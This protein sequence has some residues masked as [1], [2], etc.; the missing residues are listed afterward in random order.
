MHLLPFPPNF[1]ELYNWLCII[2]MFKILIPFYRH[3][4]Y[5]SL[6][7]IHGL[8]SSVLTVSFTWPLHSLNLYLF[9]NGVDFFMIFLKD[10][11]MGTT[12][13]ELFYVWRCSFVDFES[14]L[15]V[16]WV[17]PF[18]NYTLF[19]INK[20][21]GSI[22]S[23][24][25]V[26]WDQLN[27]SLLDFI[28]APTYNTE[29]LL[30]KNLVRIYINANYFMFPVL[31]FIISILNF[32]PFSLQGNLKLYIFKYYGFYFYLLHFS[33][34]DSYSHVGISPAVFLI[35]YLPWKTLWLSGI[36]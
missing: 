20:I 7:L 25:G 6:D 35:I 5:G 17:Y 29:R 10:E 36:F 30:P 27:P 2:T 23:A 11:I 26:I 22:I 8:S 19:S 14:E 1:Y 24:T 16:C 18:L 34:Q 33:I 13:P 4:S 21:E 28:Y 15:H 31:D 12:F 9:I 32:Q 3:S